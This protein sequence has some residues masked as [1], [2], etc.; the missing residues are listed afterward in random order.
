MK[1][2]SER[3]IQRIGG[4]MSK[5]ENSHD[6]QDEP[7]GITEFLFASK[8]TDGH[9]KCNQKRKEHNHVRLSVNHRSGVI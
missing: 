4:M 2:L 6:Q 5:P 9:N 3:K 7:K 1:L 8:S